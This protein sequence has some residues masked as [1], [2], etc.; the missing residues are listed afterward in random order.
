M[1]REQETLK[2]KV[3]ELGDPLRRL[4]RSHRHVVEVAT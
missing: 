3:R 4:L 1:T 2:Q